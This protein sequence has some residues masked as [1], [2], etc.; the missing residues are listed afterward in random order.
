MLTD[1]L[2][3]DG[4]SGGLLAPTARMAATVYVAI[5]LAPGMSAGAAALW[6]AHHGSPDPVVLTA[7]NDLRALSYFVAL[8]AFALFLVTIGIAGRLTGRLPGWAVWSALAIGIAI[9]ASLPWAAANADRRVRAARTALGRGCRRPP[10]PEPGCP[11]IGSG[12][13]TRLPIPAATASRC[14]HG[15]SG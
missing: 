6:L 11:P 5:C 3:G 7:L 2:R 8:V 4:L 15:H 9:V 10:A 13:V 1:R 12:R 14:G